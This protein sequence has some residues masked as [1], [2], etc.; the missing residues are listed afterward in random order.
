M[1]SIHK[2]QPDS[3]ELDFQHEQT[4]MMSARYPVTQVEHSDRHCAKGLSW[5]AGRF[6]R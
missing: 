6:Q 2:N 5:L 1:N 4:L 3:V